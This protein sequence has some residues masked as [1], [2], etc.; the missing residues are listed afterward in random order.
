MNSFTLVGILLFFT[1]C[2]TYANAI[3]ITQDI[4]ESSAIIIEKSS[5]ENQMDDLLYKTTDTITLTNNEISHQPVIE[6][7]TSKPRNGQSA[8]RRRPRH[9]KNNANH[10]QTIDCRTTTERTPKTTPTKL[11]AHFPSIF[12]SHSWGPGW[13]WTIFQSLF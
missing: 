5:Y 13:F 11:Y 9:R 7:P 12:I 10:S 6:K 1:L 4:T 2:T 8:Q 3:P